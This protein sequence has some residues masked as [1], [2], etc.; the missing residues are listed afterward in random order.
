MTKG[1]GFAVFSFFKIMKKS[2]LIFAAFA[3]VFSACSVTPKSEQER[4]KAVKDQLT[5][6][7]KTCTGASCAATE[8]KPSCLKQCGDGV[9]WNNSDICDDE[10]CPCLE[11][12]ESCAADCSLDTDE[13]KKDD[14]A[15]KDDDKTG[16][17]TTIANPASVYCEE[18]EGKVDIRTA[19]DGSQTGYCIF[20]AGG[21]CEEWAFYRDECQKPAND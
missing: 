13:D 1:C 3:L 15:P 16:E 20:P 17:T 12:A 8:E 21:E 19:A 5:E 7:E 6:S 10:V 14:T 18:Q 4:Q 2:F 9:C 11:S